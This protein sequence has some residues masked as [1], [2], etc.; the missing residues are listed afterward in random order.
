MVDNLKKDPILIDCTL[1]DG[2]YYNKWDFDHVLVL[3]LIHI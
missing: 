1:R 2:G 3:S